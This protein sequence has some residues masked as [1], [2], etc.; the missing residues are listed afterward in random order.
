MGI[1]NKEI[2]SADQGV[3]PLGITAKSTAASV[4]EKLQENRRERFKI[5]RVAATI[6]GVD[7]Q[8]QMKKTGHHYASETHRV[9]GCMW[10][11]LAN[12]VE[13]MRS[14]EHHT[15]HIKNVMTC[16]SVW[17][18][19]VCTAKIQERRRLEIAEAMKAWYAEGGQVIMVTLTAPHY[20]HQSLRELREMQKTAL[21]HLR[22]SGAYTRWLKQEQGFVGLIRAL[23]VTVSKRNGWHL[24][25]HELWFVKGDANVKRIKKRTL[26]RWEAACYN[27]GLLN[28]FDDKQVRAFRRR[29]VDIKGNASCSEYLAKMDDAKHWGADREI[30]KQST[31][32]GRKSGYHPFGLLSEVL[33]KGDESEWCKVRFSEYANGMKGARQLF[34]SPGLKAKFEIGEKSDEDIA[35]EETDTLERV[36]SIDKTLWYAIANAGARS[37]LL[38]VIELCDS[39]ALDDFLNS[40]KK[41]NQ[42]LEPDKSK[43]YY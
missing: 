16:G 11:A 32:Q 20:N 42:K 7:A 9:C 27:A 22:K 13:L 19:P 36:R 12:N 31:K 25:T 14:H 30:A 38:E 4:G 3:S 17:S 29:A 35:A 34:W 6:L 26:E 39:R 15:A 43:V 2:R 18:C 10:T 41:A 33:N 8:R 28:A 1:S 40:F 23:E 24:H 21:T 37:T 5:Q